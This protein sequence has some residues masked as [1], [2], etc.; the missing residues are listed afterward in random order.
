M[1]HFLL[2]TPAGI[3][4]LIV[5]CSLVGFSGGR[6]HRHRRRSLKHRTPHQKLDG[7]HAAEKEENF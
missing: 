2:H 5:L 3:V 6:I 7:F 1:I 4:L